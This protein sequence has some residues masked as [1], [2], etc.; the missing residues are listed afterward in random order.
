[1]THSEKA[2]WGLL[3]LA[4]AIIVVSTLD[5]GNLGLRGLILALGLLPAAIALTRIAPAGTLDGGNSRKILGAAFAVHVLATLFFFPLPDVVNGLPPVTLDHSFHYYQAVR[6]RDVFWETLRID[7]YDPYFMAGYPGGTIFDLDMKAAEVFC[8][9]VPVVNVARC[10]K[11]FIL[12]AYLGM[13]PALYLGS[14]LQGFRREE[15]LLGV[16]LFLAYWHWGR[17]YAG[18]FR[19]AGMFSFVFASHLCFLLVGLLREVGLGRRMWSFL[20][21]GPLAFMVH[22]T[23]AVMLPVPISASLAADRRHWHCRRWLVLAVWCLVVVGVNAF[24]LRPFFSYVWMK[25]TTQFYYQVDGFGG[26]VR[27]LL[28]PGG[29]IALAMMGLAIVGVWRLAVERRLSAGLPALMGSAA[30]FVVAAVGVR[31]WAI[32]QL[33]PGRFLLSAI[34]F[35]TPLAGVGAREARERLARLFGEGGAAARVRSWVFAAMVLVMLPLAML[36]SKAYYRHTIRT[37][38]TA[39]VS[40]LVEA[41]EANVDREGRL[42]IEDCPAMFYGDVHLPA[43]LPLSTGAEQ[44]GGPYPHTFLLYYFATFRYEG[45]FGRPL[46]EWDG[47]GLA[48]HL[49]FYRVRCVVTATEGATRAMAALLEVP[50]VWVSPPYALWRLEGKD[51]N[52]GVRSRARMNRIEVEVDGGE[53]GYLLEY[54]W[55]PGLSVSRP[56]TI[57]PR[58]VL[59]DP[60]PFIYLR[61]GGARAIAITY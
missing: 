53:D 54:H 33:E 9:I 43:L 4:A 12:G 52:T 57:E 6:A 32:D 18:N 40:A 16:L 11:L 56:A 26:L 8:G 13:V 1:M 19:Y 3:I 41:I 27:I 28:K 59:D 51:L 38:Y 31:M 39:E 22:P 48:R 34:M 49:D 15:S 7:R 61:P 10:L 29:V 36:E 35:L 24:W 20:I 17:P 14:R 47:P 50:P 30:L 45:T 60:V 55:V 46:E 42:M 58:H 21:L 37:T 25:T 23:A 5:T 44:I 2:T